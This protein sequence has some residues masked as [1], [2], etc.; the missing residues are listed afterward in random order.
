MAELTRNLTFDCVADRLQEEHD[1]DAPAPGSVVSHILRPAQ[2]VTL[3][4]LNVHDP[5]QRLPQEIRDQTGEVDRDYPEI[6]VIRL[7]NARVSGGGL[8]VTE[9]G[10]LLRESNVRE[11]HIER[12]DTNGATLRE[13]PNEP[14]AH[15][16]DRPT[17]FLNGFMPFHYG[18]WIYDNFS[19]LGLAQQALG[20]RRYTVLC[21]HKERRNEWLR[22]D[23]TQGRMLEFAGVGVDQVHRLAEHEWALVD[24]LVVISPLNNF[25][26]PAQGIFSQPEMFQF[27]KTLA[28][29]AEARGKGPLIY[30]SRRDTERRILVNEDDVIEIL[31]KRFGF[32]EVV[33]GRHNVDEQIA[34]FRDAKMVVGPVGNAFMNMVYSPPSTEFIPFLPPEASDMLPYYQTFANAGRFKINAMIASD[35]S[36]TST[37]NRLKDVRWSI[38]P[39]WV[40]DFVSTLL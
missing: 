20:S 38:D 11:P 7:R 23:T 16:K 36:E 28:G 27:I 40:A 39:K 29:K 3:S 9:S 31:E 12:Q 17:I 21:G 30:C 26:P 18:H 8:A 33:C 22:P 13:P 24:D 32:V 4:T 14:V 10:F 5:G 25:R 1:F 35:R 19:R 6:A 15:L 34:I 2:N 37:S